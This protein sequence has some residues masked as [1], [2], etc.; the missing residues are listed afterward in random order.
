MFYQLNNDLSCN[1]AKTINNELSSMHYPTIYKML[2]VTGSLDGWLNDRVSCQNTAPILMILAF[3]IHF[4]RGSY[5]LCYFCKNI[6]KWLH[7]T[8]ICVYLIISY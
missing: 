3:E 8:H 5:L 4:G 2:S 1:L 7:S 6:K